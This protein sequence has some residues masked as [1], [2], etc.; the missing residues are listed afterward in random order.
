MDEKLVT[1][2][3]ECDAQVMTWLWNSLEPEVLNNVSVAEISKE[4][5]EA[6]RE[7]YSSDQDIFCTY[8]LY[9][10]IFSC[11]QENLYVDEYY[12]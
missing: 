11:T 3:E 4:I 12:S 6:L 10:D 1:V 5:W 7:I 8:Q 2:W 9:Q